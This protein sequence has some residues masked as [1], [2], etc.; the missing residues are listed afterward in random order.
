[1]LD[2]RCTLLAADLPRVE[3]RLADCPLLHAISKRVAADCCLRLGLDR[4]LILGIVGPRRQEKSR[5][6][7]LKGGRHVSVSGYL[8]SPLAQP[9]LCGI[10]HRALVREGAPLDATTRRFSIDCRPI[11]LPL[12]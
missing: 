1:M 10:A 2:A 3:A 9:L 8:G 7:T 12:R 6:A 11:H 4:L 5:R